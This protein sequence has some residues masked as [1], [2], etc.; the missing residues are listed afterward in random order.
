MYSNFVYLINCFSYQFPVVDLRFSNRYL[1]RLKSYMHNKT[2]P[3]DFTAKGYIAEECLTF[4]S[5]YFKSIETIFNRLVRN[6]KE[7]MGAMMSIT[8]DSNSWI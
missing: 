3:E 4:C 1:S 8:L 2:Y 7:S 5:R 6:V